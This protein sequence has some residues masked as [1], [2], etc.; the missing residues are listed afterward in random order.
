MSVGRSR[1]SLSTS[2][3]I[4][5]YQLCSSEVLVVSLSIIIIVPADI[6]KAW[7]TSPTMAQSSTRYVA[8]VLA[9]IG[10]SFARQDN[11]QPKRSIMLGKSERIGKKARR[12]TTRDL[13]SAAGRP[14]QLLGACIMHEPFLVLLVHHTRT[15]FRVCHRRTRRCLTK[16]TRSAGASVLPNE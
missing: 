15:R 11:I 9:I 3:P 16:K 8:I 4:P 1:L 14:S 7:P 13:L 12:T 6:R 10:A 2:C 5:S